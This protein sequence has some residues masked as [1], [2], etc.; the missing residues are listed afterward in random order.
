MVGWVSRVYLSLWIAVWRRCALLIKASRAHPEFAWAEMLGSMI[1]VS[2][3]G[4][5]VG[6]AFLSLAYWDMPYY[7]VVAAVVGHWIV[8]HGGATEKVTKSAWQR[9]A[10]TTQ[11]AV[12]KTSRPNPT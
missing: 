6:G 9:P 3:I 2:T 11:Q 5:L 12:A 4:Y 7:L 10:P 8:R 1:Q